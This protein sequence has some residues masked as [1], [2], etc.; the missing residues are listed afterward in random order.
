MN[1]YS[2]TD[3]TR[4]SASQ[5]FLFYVFLCVRVKLRHFSTDV[6]AKTEA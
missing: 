1:F 6:A 2:F 5:R 3:L 4:G